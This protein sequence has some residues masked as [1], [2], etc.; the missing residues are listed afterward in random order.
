MLKASPTGQDC[1]QN[2][3]GVAEDKLEGGDKVKIEAAIQ[4]TLDW[5]Y[6][7]IMIQ[8]S[9]K[10]KEP[11]ESINHDEA[12]EYGAAVRSAILTECNHYEPWRCAAPS[13]CWGIGRSGPSALK[14]L[15][16]R[17]HGLVTLPA[18]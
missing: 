10:G 16:Q 3:L 2:G 4:E 6:N 8:E 14:M 18:R 13:N 15:Q 12:V 5:L 11:S 17:F 1:S 9:F 7:A